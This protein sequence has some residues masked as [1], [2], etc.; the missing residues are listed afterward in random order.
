MVRVLRACDETDVEVHVVPRFFELG[1]APVGNDIEYVWGIPLLRLHRA[2]LRSPLWRVK[3]PL[4]VVVAAALLVMTAPLFG[5]IGVCIRL[6]D[7]GPVFFRQTRVGQRGR[8]ITIFK[9]RTLPMSDDSDH[10]WSV[11]G[12]AGM[13]RIG[14][15]L[16]ATSLDELPQLLNVLRG[17][18]SLVGPRPER[19]TFVD[20][21][22][23][24]YPHYR[25]RHRVPVGMTG[26][27]QV[28]GLRGD[29]SID[30]RARFDNYYIEHWGL[31]RDFTILL[32]SILPVLCLSG[33][34]VSGRSR[35]VNLPE[36]EPH[37]LNATEA[38]TP[39][40]ATG[41][42][43]FRSADPLF[44]TPGTKVAQDTPH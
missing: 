25:D 8:L 30:E 40:S 21:F 42:E 39:A 19:P 14:R 5:L 7:R 38:T 27:A 29:T 28:N 41:T 23:A 32:C 37:P 11:D 17:D 34:P 26:W 1:V 18:M 22:A 10:V 15:F 3:R 24:S 12:H 9:F 35:I 31:W 13:T 43:S 2:A 44:R 16:R 4:D 20:K 6:T 33:R 36:T